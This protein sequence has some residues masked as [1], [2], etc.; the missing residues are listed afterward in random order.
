MKSKKKNDSDKT[1][2]G[3]AASE[4]NNGTDARQDSRIR[5][6]YEAEAE[7]KEL[8]ALLGK[9]MAFSRM[10]RSEEAS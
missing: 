7:E 3:A 10:M 5:G 9:R 6:E 4:R 2:C 1:L 8:K